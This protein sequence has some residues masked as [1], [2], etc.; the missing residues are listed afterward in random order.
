MQ[1][2]NV[3]VNV[4]DRPILICT[5]DKIDLHEHHMH[6]IRKLLV[7]VVYLVRTRLSICTYMYAY[8]GMAYWYV[9]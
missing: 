3:H 7:C 9:T 1:H 5:I 4:V 2:V 6:F 8:N